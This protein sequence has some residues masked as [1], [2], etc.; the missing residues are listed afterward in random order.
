M[1]EPQANLITAHAGAGDT[2]PN[3]REFLRYATQSYA[4]IIEIDV[5]R[6]EDGHLIAAHSSTTERAE[7]L[8]SFCQ[9]LASL[10]SRQYLNFD[11][12]A[13][14]LEKKTVEILW[15]TG[16]AQRSMYSGTVDYKLWQPLPLSVALRLPEVMLNAENCELSAPLAE[17]GGSPQQRL[18]F[19]QRNMA[20]LQEIKLRCG[21]DKLNLAFPMVDNFVRNYLAERGFGLSVWT[22]DESQ[23]IS[24]FWQMGVFNLTTNK[25]TEAAR[26]RRE[27][28]GF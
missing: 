19:W 3:S 5:S 7:E 21:I 26:L 6:R 2:P 15:M 14:G 27:I 18:I 17:R 24:E 23:A 11:L 22:V 12:K 13:P 8:T 4:D 1:H 16:L 25:V 20:K 28:H 10:P 9:F